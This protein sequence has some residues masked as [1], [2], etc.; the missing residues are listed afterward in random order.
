MSI[1]VNQGKIEGIFNM[2]YT[3]Q[4]KMVE[5]TI[6]LGV[7]TVESLIQEFEDSFDMLFNRKITDDDS[8]I[9]SQ[10][11][12]EYFPK[13]IGR[14]LIWTSQVPTCRKKTTV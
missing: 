6:T 11:L 14:F 7:D 3:Y 10:C 1:V 12:R 4:G 2:A 8:K 13:R 9:F 5:F